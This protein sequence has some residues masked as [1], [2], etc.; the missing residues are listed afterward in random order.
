M[1]SRFIRRVENT[2]QISLSSHCPTLT[3]SLLHCLL[4]FF[5]GNEGMAIVKYGC[6]ETVS[7]RGYRKCSSSQLTFVISLRRKIG[8]QLAIVIRGK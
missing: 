1:G 6:N 8:G 5:Y 3:D 4:F 7:E 2:M